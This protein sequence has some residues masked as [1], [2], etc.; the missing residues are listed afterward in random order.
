MVT[1]RLEPHG[2]DILYWNINHQHGGHGVSVAEKSIDERSIK[3]KS[4]EDNDDLRS[5]KRLWSLSNVGDECVCC[6]RNY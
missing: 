2:G 4:I 6:V 3:E 1:P 5:L